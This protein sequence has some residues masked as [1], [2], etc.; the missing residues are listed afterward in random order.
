MSVS[1]NLLPSA[2]DW[3]QIKILNDR[4]QSLFIYQLDL[5]L[6]LGDVVLF[7]YTRRWINIQFYIN[8]WSVDMYSLLHNCTLRKFNPQSPVLWSVKCFSVQTKYSRSLSL[9]R[10]LYD[11]VRKIEFMI[12]M[13]W[14]RDTICRSFTLGFAAEVRSQHDRTLQW[15]VL[16]D[17]SVVKPE[18][19][20]RHGSLSPTN[21]LSCWN[22]SRCR[23]LL[24]NSGR[25]DQSSLGHRNDQ[26]NER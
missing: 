14:W 3:Y 13:W 21:R 6:L 24:Q 5:S 16:V 7:T 12:S 22:H 17:G 23:S 15:A 18:S 20:H 9:V 10:E 2:N 11:S 25:V 26:Q 4:L 1:L 19:I 8:F